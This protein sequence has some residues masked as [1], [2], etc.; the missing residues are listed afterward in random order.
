MAPT[1]D[2]LD[3]VWIHPGFGKHFREMS[4]D[5]HDVTF[6]NDEE[7]QS[8]EAQKYVEYC[9]AITDYFDVLL[10]GS[11]RDCGLFPH[12]MMLEVV[13]F[14]SYVKTL[15]ESGYYALLPDPIKNALDID[16][17][18][19]TIEELQ[20]EVG[21]LLERQNNHNPHNYYNDDTD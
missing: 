2:R 18:N 12:E 3:A 11:V 17:P 7:Y 8:E 5:F 1:D 21:L 6:D 4:G 10:G 20:N 19:P 14:K 16:Q 13:R 9:E 15:K